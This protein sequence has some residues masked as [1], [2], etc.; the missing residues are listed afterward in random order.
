MAKAIAT[1]APVLVAQAIA[2]VAFGYALQSWGPRTV[3]L[4]SFAL[5][6]CSLAAVG[7]LAL[8]LKVRPS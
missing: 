5:G 1:A 7:W 4:A 6:L 2:P 8:R 3:L